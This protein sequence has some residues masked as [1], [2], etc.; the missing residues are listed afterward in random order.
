MARINLEEMKTRLDQQNSG[1]FISSFYLKGDGSHN[2]VKFLLNSVNDIE[3]FSVHSVRLAG[4]NGNYFNSVN[5]KGGD[6][7]TLC[8]EA[9]NHT[10]EKMPLVSRTRDNV[11][12]PV[13]VMYDKE[14]K[15][16]PYYAVWERSTKFFRDTLAP[17]FARYDIHGAFE[18]ERRG[19]APQVQYNIYNVDKDFEG[20]KIDFTKSVEDYKAEFNV[21]DDDIF[22]R[23]D[24]YIH[25]WD[26]E[27]IKLFVSTGKFPVIKNDGNGEAD[28][29]QPQEQPQRRVAPRTF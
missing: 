7:C 21:K 11:Y 24:S 25:D 15:F 23:P 19:V 10:A 1:S 2:I 22:G 27:Q 3:I 14:G 9:V 17:T 5:C 26:D 18:I 4:K 13:I 29:A 8:R 16:N 12:I 20:N 28:E 6:D